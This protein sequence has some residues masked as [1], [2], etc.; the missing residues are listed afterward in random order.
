MRVEYHFGRYERLAA[1]L[2]ADS[3]PAR[4]QQRRHSRSNTACQLVQHGLLSGNH[5]G[6]ITR[7]PEIR[8]IRRECRGAGQRLRRL[9]GYAGTQIQQ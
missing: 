3:A 5:F 9:R 4:L 6:K 8:A 1:P 7:I 2:V